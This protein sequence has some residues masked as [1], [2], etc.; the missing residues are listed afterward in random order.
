MKV[1]KL[2]A[3]AMSMSLVLCA[4]AEKKQKT[5]ENS[6]E[7]STEPVTE[8]TE[9][10]EPPAPEKTVPEKMLENMTL[11]QKVCQMFITTPEQLS[12]WDVVTLYDEIVQDSI[13]D[14]PIG[15]MVM[16]YYNFETTEQTAQLISDIQECVLANSG[17]GMFM[18]VDEE[19]GTV[20]DVAN[21]IGDTYFDDMITYG[22]QNDTH[23]SYEIGYTIGTYLKALGF[24]LD[25]A[26]VA[27]VNIGETT[28]LGGRIFSSDPDVVASMSSNVAIGLK[29]AGVFA[30]LKYFP[31][32]GTSD[33]I[34]Y[35]DK[36]VAVNRSVD[37]LRATDFVS[38]RE[39]INAGADFV[40]VGHQV[41]SGVGD[42][43]PSDL[44]YTVV[45]ELLR[46]EL[47]FNGIIITDS[48]MLENISNVYTSAEASV[49]AINAGVD[50]I[51]MPADLS[52]S[53][54]AVCTAVENGEID[55][56]RIDESVLRILNKKY[57]AGLLDVNFKPEEPTEATTE[58]IT[59][60]STEE[61]T[62][63]STEILT[64]EITTESVTEVSS[65]VENISMEKT[66]TT[67]SGYV[68]GSF[69]DPNAI[70][71]TTTTTTVPEYDYSY[72]YN[73]GYY[74]YGYDGNYIDDDTYDY[75]YDYSYDYN[76]DYG[77]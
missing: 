61:T 48:H 37:D 43:L 65:V 41:I 16:S 66:T 74:D 38:F 59:E 14:C 22:E 46:N 75:T 68:A 1:K 2:M 55:S 3:M 12:G 9:P 18:A 44:S 40:M 8:V 49:M 47:E 34:N 69:V 57:D 35:A 50:M 53:I 52:E 77:Y 63:E 32:V 70:T 42:W 73:Q 13:I 6:E 17:I 15:G 29:D 39:G 25:F 76:Y 11:Q 4:C 7:P 72:D 20:A 23:V 64:E 45:T 28:E 27:D 67:F 71:T 19:G 26:P 62:T 10:T 54:E 60:E 21:T 24:N 5:D 33:G 30:T 31:G 51:L 36:D 58:A 56:A